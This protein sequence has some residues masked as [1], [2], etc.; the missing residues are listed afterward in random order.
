MRQDRARHVP[1]GM[2]WRPP[3][4]FGANRPSSW[5]AHG[6]F[7]AM[8][9]RRRTELETDELTPPRARPARQPRQ[10]GRR[11]EGRARRRSSDRRRRRPA[12]ATG[13]PRR[14]PGGRPPHA[15]PRRRGGRAPSVARRRPVRR[16]RAGVS[17]ATGGGAARRRGIGGGRARAERRLDVVSRPNMNATSPR[18]APPTRPSSR[19]CAGTTTPNWT[20]CATGRTGAGRGRDDRCVAAGRARRGVGAGA[21][22]HDGAGSPRRPRPTNARSPPLR[23][24]QRE[25]AERAATHLESLRA[26]H[27]AAL[28]LEQSRAAAALAAAVADHEAALDRVE[29]SQAAA[30]LELGAAQDR[31]REAVV[32]EL[33]ARLDRDRDDVDASIAAQATALDEVRAQVQRADDAI[34]ATPP[35]RRGPDSGRGDAAH[36]GARTGGRR[37]HAVGACRA[38]ARIGGR[39]HEA[40]PR[41]GQRARRGQGPGDGGRAPAQAT[42]QQRHGAAPGA[43][44]GVR[45][46]GRGGESRSIS[47]CARTSSPSGPSSRKFVIA[48]MESSCGRS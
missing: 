15:T 30:L 22:A 19:I 23:Q 6:R 9:L 42:G 32:G 8:V 5:L 44:G 20:D 14:P 48:S 21:I 35:R 38:A 1:A 45:T 34:A 26:E 2:S 4:R 3:S 10:A 12:S 25:S 31:A 37:R 36:R 28:E 27:A 24:E 7:R 40:D 16:R 39:R 17:G 11:A 46:A 47:P 18:S 43:H 33:H 13:P 29:Q 41:A